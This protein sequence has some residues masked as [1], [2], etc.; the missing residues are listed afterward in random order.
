MSAITTT[1]PA[2]NRGGDNPPERE[3]PSSSSGRTAENPMDSQIQTGPEN[4]L[5]STKTPNSTCS[6]SKNCAP[7]GIAEL[8]LSF[9]VT[10][11]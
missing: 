7:A 6:D 5:D 2:G 9:T 3:T 10:F 8:F 1:I 11:Y 4:G